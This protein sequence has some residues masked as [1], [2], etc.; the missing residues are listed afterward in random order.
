MWQYLHDN[1]TK[2]KEKKEN[3]SHSRDLEESEG[4]NSMQNE[5]ATRGQ[6]LCRSSCIK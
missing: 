5:A 6:I 4:C 1:I 3:L 2:A